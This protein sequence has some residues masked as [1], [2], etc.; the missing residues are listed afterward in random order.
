MS[1]RERW[2]AAVFVCA[3]LFAVTANLQAA[4]VIVNAPS[5]VS[6]VNAPDQFETAAGPSSPIPTLQIQ[7]DPVGDLDRAAGSRPARVVPIGAAMSDD[8]WLAEPSTTHPGGTVEEASRPLLY[9][10]PAEVPGLVGPGRV[11]VEL[12]LSDG[13]TA[14][15]VVPYASL[16]YDIKGDT[17]IYTSP[18]Q[19]VFVRHPVQVDYIDNGWAVLNEG[20]PAGTA[21]VA[22][23]VAELYGTEFKIGK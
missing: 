22:V 2:L 12:T 13:R 14:R 19:L 11:L 6:G 1:Y 8:G 23:G 20:P 5:K 9:D 21:V 15:K 7:V 3:G 18:E 16:L 10:L 4:E 17:W